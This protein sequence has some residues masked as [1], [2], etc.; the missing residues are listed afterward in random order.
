MEF[1]VQLPA[2]PL[3]E[4]YK[5]NR[6]K[7]LIYLNDALYKDYENSVEKIKECFL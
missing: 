3:T 4:A 1:I 5:I 7:A 2:A 6:E